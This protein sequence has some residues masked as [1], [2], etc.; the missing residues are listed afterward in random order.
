MIL[1][2]LEV[3]FCIVLHCLMLNM[4]SVSYWLK[5]YVFNLVLKREFFLLWILLYQRY[6][7][8]HSLIIRISLTQGLAST[9]TISVRK[10]DHWKA[11]C[12]KS[13]QQNQSWKPGSQSQSNAH[14]PP[15]G[16]KSPHHNTVA[17][18]SSSSITDPSTRA[19]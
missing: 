5:Q 12:P 8:S 10:K 11:Q 2:D 4:L 17:V 1:K 19:A 7:L 9:S 13:R 18:T 16:Y 15:Q 3:Q 6:P 14:R